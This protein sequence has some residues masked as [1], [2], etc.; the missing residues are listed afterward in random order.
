TPTA[1]ALSTP[2][3]MRLASRIRNLAYSDDEGRASIEALHGCALSAIRTGALYEVAAIPEVNR[4]RS[5]RA[6]QQVLFAVDAFILAKELRREFFGEKPG[7]APLNARR[8]ATWTRKWKSPAP[9]RKVVRGFYGQDHRG[10]IW[11][12]GHCD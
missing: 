11:R 4:A 5:D 6:R 2:D 8:F 9:Q 10:D 7:A 12:P 1:Q 3:A